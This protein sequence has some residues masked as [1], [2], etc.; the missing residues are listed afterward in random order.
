MITGMYLILSWGKLFEL[1]FTRSAYLNCSYQMLNPTCIKLTLTVQ[2]QKSTWYIKLSIKGIYEVSMH[3]G[4]LRW[5]SLLCIYKTLKATHENQNQVIE[6][7]CI[8][9]YTAY[10]SPTQNREQIMSLKQKYNI[11]NP[12]KLEDGREVHSGYHQIVLKHLQCYV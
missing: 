10:L 3:T 1:T 12:T 2:V 9:F 8:T 11:I 7:N 4:S 6:I 5:E